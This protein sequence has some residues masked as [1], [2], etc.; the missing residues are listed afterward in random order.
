MRKPKGYA[1]EC[2][3]ER[4]AGYTLTTLAE[5]NPD[6]PAGHLVGRVLA[7]DDADTFVVLAMCE[8]ETAE[9]L[10][11]LAEL[12]EDGRL[13]ETVDWLVDREADA[14]WAER[15]RQAAQEA[16]DGSPAPDYAA[17]AHE[18]ATGAHSG[19][20]VDAE[21]EPCDCEGGWVET[22]PGTFAPCP[23][24]RRSAAA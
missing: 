17:E 22:E 19:W 9:A 2:A 20:S 18:P 12:N 10:D 8:D 1:T 5:E 14:Q 21:A 3:R 13:S 16:A 24:C 7:V 23:R 4:L 15:Q 6:W 11:A